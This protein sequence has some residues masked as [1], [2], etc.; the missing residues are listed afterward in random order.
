[1]ERLSAAGAAFRDTVV[2]GV[3]GR[4]ILLDDPSGNPVELFQPT[5]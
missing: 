2:T 5:S 1:M 3:G 4:Q